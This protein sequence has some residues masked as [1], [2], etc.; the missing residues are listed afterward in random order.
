[1]ARPAVSS[2]K[3]QPR[4][5]II[6]PVLNEARGIAATLAALRPLAAE[7]MRIWVM[8]KRSVL[9]PCRLPATLVDGS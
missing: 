7:I 5:S 1:M 3:A 8:A 9:L 6:L 2:M 4:L